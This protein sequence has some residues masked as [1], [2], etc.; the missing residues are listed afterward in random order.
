[1]NLL[2]LVTNDE[3][4]DIV[5]QPADF[6][7]GPTGSQDRAALNVSM[8]RELAVAQEELFV[9]LDG[10]GGTPES[11]EVEGALADGV[12]VLAGFDKGLKALGHLVQYSQPSVPAMMP[13]LSAKRS[14][15]ADA[16][17]SANVVLDLLESVGLD[18]AESVVVADEAEA[19][20]VAARL[21]FPLVA[22]IANEGL[23][24]KSDQ[25]GVILD[26]T[27]HWELTHALTQLRRIG[28]TRFEIQRQITEGF[29]I[30]LGLRSD[31]HLGSFII[32]GLGGIWAEMLDDVQIRP[33]G[34]RA[35]EAHEMIRMLRGF[36]RLT[37][38]R[39]SE[40]VDLGLI[41]DCLSKIDTLGLSI[42][43]LIESLD[44]NPMIVTKTAA[45]TVDAL[46][47]RRSTE[48]RTHT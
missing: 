2:E 47:V 7:V 44:I 45:V 6:T 28:A 20:V 29:E 11:L 38:A 40:P 39:G 41:A 13:S 42:G 15:L 18:V 5:V 3:N 4:V 46:L 30:Y 37:G 1:M 33:V 34:L 8:A 35:G 31:P 21:G 25:G 43:D 27:S 32:L 26:I 14:I 22:K 48:H 17:D 12:L 16:S 19:G 23:V 9:V 24:H 36:S 10:V